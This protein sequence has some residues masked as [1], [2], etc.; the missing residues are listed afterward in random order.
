MIEEARDCIECGCRHFLL[1][2]QFERNHR[3]VQKWMC[4]NCGTM[5]TK[6]EWN[7]LESPRK[8]SLEYR[9]SHR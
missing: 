6:T 2:D 7:G 9:Q 1:V 3:V 8:R 4:R 5:F